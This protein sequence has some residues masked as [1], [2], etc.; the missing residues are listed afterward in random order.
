MHK[1][2]RR[3]GAERPRGALGTR[4]AT[5]LR[6]R[7]SAACPY[8]R[9]VVFPFGVGGRQ[10]AVKCLLLA[11]ISVTLASC[12]TATST[13]ASSTHTNPA[14][15]GKSHTAQPGNGLSASLTAPGGPVSVVGPLP[16][17]DALAPFGG[18]D[19][20]QG[21]WRPAGRRVDGVPV[22]YE[23]TLVPP[24]GTGPA[25]IAWLDTHLLAARLYSGTGSPGGGPYRFTAPI[26][27]TQA[28]SLV[29][30]FNGGFLMKQALG[31][32]YTEGRTIYPLRS[33]A[34]SLVIYADGRVDVGEWDRDVV[35]TPDVVSVRQ[36]LL[37]LVAGGQ[38]TPLAA[39]A[40][41]RSWGATCGATSCSTPGVEHQWR[42]GVG[43]TSDGALVY[44]TGPT[45]APG[46]LAQ[47]L[48]RAGVV[49][50]MQLDINPNWPVF[51][52]YDPGGQGLA[53]PSNGTR[54]LSSTRQGPATFFT[55]SWAR[56]FITMSVRP[57]DT[58]H[59]RIVIGSPRP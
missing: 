19:P 45:L 39:S 53:A 8:Y 51:A 38:A 5:W 57:D 20:A 50:G 7:P 48:V 11:G 17:P 37:P 27:P 44:V 24:G 34:A 54:L 31:G 6:T 12:A 14:I 30:A 52:A 46:Q 21:T 49:R 55:A 40:D 15:I 47:L 43:V 25:G 42:S 56:D 3:I 10:R 22:V 33:G 28:A 2:S 4:S 26:Q 18:T 13:A 36:N 16:A 41:W 29:A 1:R 23:T 32:Y 9:G 59:P 35:M 58:D